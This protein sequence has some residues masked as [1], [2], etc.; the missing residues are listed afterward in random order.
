MSETAV[1]VPTPTHRDVRELSPVLYDRKQLFNLREI[2]KNVV[3]GEPV[4]GTSGW[5][6]PAQTPEDNE[7]RSIII[8]L[9]KNLVKD[10]EP[11]YKYNAEMLRL[12]SSRT[13]FVPFYWEYGTTKVPGQEDREFPYIAMEHVQGRTLRK[14]M[15]NSGLTIDESLRILKTI[16]R[17]VDEL[18]GEGP[19]GKQLDGMPPIISTDLN[20][21]NI[22]MR[23][24][25]NNQVIMDRPVIIDFDGARYEKKHHVLPFG[26]QPLTP[27]YAGP[28][29]V[30]EGK[31]ITRKLNTWQLG[32]IAFEML[33]GEEFFKGEN[34]QAIYFKYLDETIFNDFLK[35]RL[36][37]VQDKK[38]RIP[39]GKKCISKATSDVLGIALAHD[40]A[41]RF[42]SATILVNAIE[43]AQRQN[44]PTS[45]AIEGRTLV[46]RIS[47]ML[48][49]P[50]SPRDNSETNQYRDSRGPGRR[51]YA[52][53]QEGAGTH[54]R[55]R[56]RSS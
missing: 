18:L 40:P 17:G 13:K 31:E 4:F 20:P 41:K 15:A 28:E 23:V 48:R 56:V 39:K 33:T 30:Q 19:D 3:W 38:K 1:E 22:Q 9:A 35:Q 14:V 37:Q 43:A 6:I 26:K 5:L 29:M 10:A 7:I 42:G 8:K 51:Y 54:R 52:R 2:G 24:D 50:S 46:R 32:A 27:A 53:H 47:N 44:I 55:G 49:P 34:N 25:D 45:P 12:A 36:E 16:A 21:N 11:H